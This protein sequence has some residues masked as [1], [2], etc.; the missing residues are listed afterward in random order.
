M[1]LRASD[2]PFIVAAAVVLAAVL[3]SVTL[4][5]RRR[6]TPAEKER[7]RRAN[8]NRIGRMTDGVIV[9][10]ES[11]PAAGKRPETALFHFVYSVGGVDYSTAQDVFTLI[12][13]IDLPPER[14]IGPVHVKY[15]PGNPSNSIIIC[16]DWSGSRPARDSAGL[17]VATVAGN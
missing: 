9:D 2:I 10:F 11:L 12:D 3:V 16:E 13:R 17:E 15:E 8:V 6:N 4:F 14:Y 1:P 5:W 7:R